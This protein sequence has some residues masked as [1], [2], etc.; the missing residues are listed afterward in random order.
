MK[1]SITQEISRGIASALPY[2][3]IARNLSNVSKA[4]LSRTKTIARTEGHRIQQTSAADAQREAKKKGADVVK[5]WD[6]SLDAR[7]RDSHA[8]IDGEI[9]EIDD[10]FSNGLRFPGD[11]NG[12]AAEVINCRCT[13]NTR[14]R[15]ALDAAELRTLQEHASFFGLDKTENFEE[16]SKKYLGAVDKTEKSG[17]LYNNKV[18]NTFEDPLREASGAGYLSNP[19]EISDMLQSLKTS[20]V[21][22][23]Y[24]ENVMCYQPGLSKGIPGKIVIDPEASFGTWSHEYTHFLD[25]KEDGFLGMRV[26]EDPQKCIEREIHA[27]NVEIEIAKNLGRPDMVERLEKL[28]RMEVERHEWNTETVG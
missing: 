23:K 18:L 15:W 26:L 11:P 3:D 5:Q 6:A 21:E 4:P 28:K 7:T 12:P 24:R 17:I 27:Y 19:S 1:K 14:A 13:A 9:R 25:D 20:G 2:R 22:V 10:K 16:Y 8:A